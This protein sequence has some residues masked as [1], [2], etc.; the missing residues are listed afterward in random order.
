MSLTYINSRIKADYEH[1]VGKIATARCVNS[2]EPIYGMVKNLRESVNSYQIGGICYL[3]DIENGDKVR[4]AD[5]ST[6][7]IQSNG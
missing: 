7:V 2:D 5:A 6:V 1:L 4:V 3:V